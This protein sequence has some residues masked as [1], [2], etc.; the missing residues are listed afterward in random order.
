MDLSFCRCLYNY[1]TKLADDVKTGEVKDL[2]AA[3]TFILKHFSSNIIPVQLTNK[4]I[5]DVSAPIMKMINHFES[6]DPNIFSRYETLLDFTATFMAKFFKNGGLK[7][8]QDV[9]NPKMLLDIDVSDRSLQLSNQNLYIGPKVEAFILQLGLTKQSI[10]LL[11]FF[12]RVRD[13]Y[14]V[15]LQRTQ[16]YFRPSLTSKLLRYCDV[17]DPKVFFAIPLDDL[18]KKMQYIGE[19]FPNVI[20]PTQ[21][22]SLL[23]LSASLRSRTRA[24][25]ASDSFTPIK[26]FS[27]LLSWDEK[28]YQLI[29][30]LGCAVLSMYGAS[31]A[32]ERDFSIMGCVLFL[33]VFKTRFIK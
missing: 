30:K 24:Q 13:F 8:E 21:I 1:F 18:K 14:V 29:G 12:D 26:F 10:E 28:K 27:V 25:K 17:L 23:D 2:T 20:K 4:F 7:E 31:T 33:L 5:L 32:A 15:A 11:P 3:E 19:K 6:E 16:K 9:A 22:P